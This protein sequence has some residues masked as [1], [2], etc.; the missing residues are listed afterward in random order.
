MEKEGLWEIGGQAVR[1]TNLDKVL[2]PA[3][4]GADHRE[5][6]VTKRDLLRYYVTV[7]GVLVPHLR[8]HGLTLQRFPD[9]V[10]RSGFW[11]KDLPSHTP[12]WVSRR[13]LMDSE[14]VKQYVVVDRVATLAWL[15]QEAAV[16]LHPW[17]A[18]D[19]NARPPALCPDRHRSGR[20]DDLGGGPRTGPPVP[21]RARAPA[22]DRFS[23][24]D[25]K[26]RRPDLGPHR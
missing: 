14:G 9:G 19:R 12:P 8:H 16:E 23:Q 15:A 10:G 20:D 18:H 26:A 5:D 17:T 1:V 24:D 22:R 25:R 4:D 7:A 6:P 2:F 21:D 13:E 11:Q 3:L